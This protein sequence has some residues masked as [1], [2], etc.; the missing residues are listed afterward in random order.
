M[1]RFRLIDSSWNLLCVQARVAGTSY[2]PC[3]HERPVGEH[4][5]AGD[6]IERTRE[7]NGSGRAMVYTATSQY[8]ITRR[9]PF[10]Y[11]RPQPRKNRRHIRWKALRIIERLAQDTT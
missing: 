8:H 10:Y 2:G 9:D 1:E 3:H 6:V 11:A 4:C 7:F 5:G